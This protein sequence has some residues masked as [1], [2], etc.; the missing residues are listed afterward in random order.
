MKS[1][2][3]RLRQGRGEITTERPAVPHDRSG[4]PPAIRCGPAV[5]DE[6]FRQQPGFS[7]SRRSHD[8]HG[9]VANNGTR[10]QSGG[11]GCKGMV[12]QSVRYR[13]PNL[14]RRLGRFV[15]GNSRHWQRPGWERGLHADSTDKHN[16]TLSE[17][18]RQA[19]PTGIC[20]KGS[21][22]TPCQNRGRSIG[23]RRRCLLAPCWFCLENPAAWQATFSETVD[24]HQMGTRLAAHPRSDSSQISQLRH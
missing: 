7:R 13:P 10:P 6:P 18:F 11:H 24:Q 2:D 23:V 16:E 20:K 1:V 12:H 14:G 22:K 15:R 21:P 5:L 17:P 19:T 8:H 3:R 9:T 4:G